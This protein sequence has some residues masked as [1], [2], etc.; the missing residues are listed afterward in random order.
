MDAFAPAFRRLPAFSLI[1]IFILWKWPAWLKSFFCLI[2][3][4][5]QH[6]NFYFFFKILIGQGLS[7][8][9]ICFSSFKAGI[10]IVIIFYKLIG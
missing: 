7:N 6:D 3:E 4:W 9:P 1:T 5:H 8:I 2:G 10:T